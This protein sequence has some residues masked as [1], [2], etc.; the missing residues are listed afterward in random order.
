MVE[1]GVLP[2][3]HESQTLRKTFGG[4]RVEKSCHF[5][6]HVRAFPGVENSRL[7]RKG[8]QVRKSV[9]Q[10]PSVSLDRGGHRWR[11]GWATEEP[12]LA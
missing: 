12:G 9:T 5:P 1:L 6:S 10:R 8:S 11:R 3:R 4:S 7:G 2:H